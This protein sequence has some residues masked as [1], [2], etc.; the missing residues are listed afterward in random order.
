M[1]ESRLFLVYCIIIYQGVILENSDAEE[2]PREPYIASCCWINRLRRMVYFPNYIST[3]T[4]E[5][6]LSA[7]Y[8]EGC[9]KHCCV[10]F[11]QFSGSVHAGGISA[12]CVLNLD[13]M[14]VIEPLIMII[15]IV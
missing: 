1:S 12:L 3:P 15:S 11:P 9:C 13:R 4:S 14:R 6:V 7:I 2:E 5:I 8:Y 10:S